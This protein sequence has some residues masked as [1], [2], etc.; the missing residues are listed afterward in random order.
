MTSSVILRDVTE[1]DLPTF[2]EQQVDPAAN[3]MAAFTR[4]DPS[5]R[6]AFM[7]HWAR[8]L[9]DDT[10]TTKTI[11]SEGHVAGH[12]AKFER[13]GKPEVTYW[14]GREY[15]GMGIATRALSGFL[16]DLKV[17]PLYARAAKD[18]K[19]SIR[20]LEKCGFTISGHDKGFAHARGEE[21][22][23]AILTLT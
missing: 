1:G 12:V 2:F 23:E 5:D 18:N 17:R 6:D 20:V 16:G 3:H 7:A 15:W 14:I 9:R 8:I 11:I 22:E 10:I 21:I 13:F 19:A 4:E